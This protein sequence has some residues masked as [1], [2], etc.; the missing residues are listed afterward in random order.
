[1]WSNS[2]SSTEPRD[3]PGPCA[4]R[5]DAGFTLIELLVV[6]VIL[7]LLA[8]LVAPRVLSYLDSARQ[9]AARI[10]IQRL[11][12]VLEYYRLDT[13]SYPSTAQGL[14]ALITPP[15]GVRGWKGP[16]V[17]GGELPVDP[18]G[19]PYRYRAPADSAPFEIVSLGADGRPGG[20]GEN[21]DISSLAR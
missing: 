16:Y 2:A 20:E 12:T 18:W 11:A 15:P 10:Q 13:G 17:D 7:A 5:R 6:L 8:G 1:M 19:R 14:E 21:A 9:D 3:R 4:A